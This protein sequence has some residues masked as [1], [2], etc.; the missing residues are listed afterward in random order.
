VVLVAGARRWV[1]TVAVLVVVLGMFAVGLT[2]H[3]FTDTVGA[4]LVGTGVL[5]LGARFA[6]GD[7][8]RS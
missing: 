5:A 6:A 2:F 3:Y 7:L 4:V 8:R 1:V